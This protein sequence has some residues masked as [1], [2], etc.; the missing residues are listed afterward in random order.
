MAEEELQKLEVSLKQVQDKFIDEWK[1][2]FEKQLDEKA[3]KNKEMLESGKGILVSTVDN[4]FF[5]EV[6]VFFF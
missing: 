6:L 4:V 1:G 3:A 2:Q 5:I